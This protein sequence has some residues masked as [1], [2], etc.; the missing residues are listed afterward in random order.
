MAGVLRQSGA[1]KSTLI[2]TIHSSERPDSGTVTVGGEDMSGFRVRD[3]APTAG[4]NS[5]SSSW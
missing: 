2:G 1:G 5:D 4:L 3:A